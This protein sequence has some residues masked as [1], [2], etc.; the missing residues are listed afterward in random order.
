[1]D[2]KEL[3]ILLRKA[4][5]LGNDIKEMEL[6]DVQAAYRKSQMKIKRQNNQRLYNLLV[7]CAAFLTIPLLLASLGLGYLYF[8]ASKEDMKYVEVT[9]TMGTV[10]RY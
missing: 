2:K 6:I 1:M 8:S 5:A 7:R 10:V 3:E 9:S 4:E